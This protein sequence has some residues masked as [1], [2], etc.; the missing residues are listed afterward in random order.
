MALDRIRGL[1]TNVTT[2]WLIF[3]WMVSFSTSFPSASSY[4]ALKMADNWCT[5]ESD[6][7][8][9]GLLRIANSL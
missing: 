8:T 9:L 4:Q 5:I 3:S 1:S 6:P 7:G 2:R